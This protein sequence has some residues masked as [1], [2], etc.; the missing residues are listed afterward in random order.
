MENPV[1]HTVDLG[2]VNYVQHP[3]NQN[4]IVYRFADNERAESFGIE[5]IEAGIWFERDEDEK[6][7]KVYFLFGVHKNDFKKT[8]RIN[9][10]VEAKHKKPFIPFKALRWIILFVGLSLL[11]LAIMGYC[12]QQQILDSYNLDNTSINQPIN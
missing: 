10:K 3:T 5:L 11:T 6:R 4:Y 2:L 7:G 8:E 1:D 12:K 9:F